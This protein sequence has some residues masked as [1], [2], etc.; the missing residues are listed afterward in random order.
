[1]GVL[2]KAM[3]RYMVIIVAGAA[4][5]SGCGTAGKTKL[6]TNVK[7][8]ETETFVIKRGARFS[9]AEKTF[10]DAARFKNVN[11]VQQVDTLIID[12]LSKKGLK[13]S[14]FP[15]GSDLFV[16]YKISFDENFHQENGEEI[17]AMNTKSPTQG[18]SEIVQ[19]PGM[20][21]LELR[22]AANAKLI[23]KN[24]VSGF[25]SSDISDKEKAERVLKI[26][27]IFLDEIPVAVN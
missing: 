10:S 9:W 16:G 5:V 18:S 4:I 11:L 12:E 8:P 21:Q 19:E 27:E 17:D 20:L 14:E 26:I 3:S 24:K 22:D 13:F 6:S 1:M 23:W 2:T 15:Q 25:I 7:I